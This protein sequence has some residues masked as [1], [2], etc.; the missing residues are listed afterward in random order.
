M[1]C[2]EFNKV[3][4]IWKHLKQEWMSLRCPYISRKEILKTKE[5]T[6][7][8]QHL[9]MWLPTKV[10]LWYAWRRILFPH[11]TFST[12]A[13]I[14]PLV[15]GWMSGS[16]SSALAASSWR[17]SFSKASK[18]FLNMPRD[19]CSIGMITYITVRKNCVI[20]FSVPQRLYTCI[21]KVIVKWLKLFQ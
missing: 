10:P 19:K 12:A 6:L 15:W 3:P 20:L 11:S 9:F 14:G 17:H 16:G 2:I 21:R 5:S 4:K 7:T 18:T 8:W 1:A 13:V